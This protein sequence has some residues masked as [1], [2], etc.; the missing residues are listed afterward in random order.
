MYELVERVYPILPGLDPAQLRL[1]NV[2]PTAH[3][4]LR[5]W[6]VPMGRVI[7]VRTYNCSHITRRECVS[8]L[9]CVPEVLTEVRGM[10]GTDTV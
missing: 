1:S 8:H 7:S 4:L 2:E 3:G 5:K 10:V 6:L 9:V